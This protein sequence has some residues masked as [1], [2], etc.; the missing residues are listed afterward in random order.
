MSFRNEGFGMKG[1]SAFPIEGRAL[2]G[3]KAHKT[4][5]VFAVWLEITV[6]HLIKLF[7][8]LS[9]PSI[10]TFTF[11]FC[12]CNGWYHATVISSYHMTEHYATPFPLLGSN[13][14]QE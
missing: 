4:N 3:E 11:L 2:S 14:S 1:S 13:Q 6:T 8:R 10:G 9:L 7:E 12:R 5:Y